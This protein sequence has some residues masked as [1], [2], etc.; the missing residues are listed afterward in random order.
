MIEFVRRAMCFTAMAACALLPLSS[1]AEFPERPVL[2]VNPYAAGGGLDTLTRAVAQRLTN[3]WG[4]QVN[5]ENRPGAGSTIGM[6]A[7]FNAKPDGYTWVVGSTPLGINPVVYPNLAY[8]VRRD[9]VPLSLIA[10]APEV[11]VVNPTLGV[12]SVAE[13]VA[14]AKGGRKMNFGSAGTGTIA[15]LAA[16][17]FIRRLALGGQHIPYKGST[18]ALVDVVGGQ[19]EGVFDTPSAVL[20]HVRSGRVRALAIA[21]PKRSAQL[22]DVPTLAEAGYPGL[23]FRTWG[24][25]LTRAGTPDAVLKRIDAGIAEVMRD[26]ALRATLTAQGWDVVGNNSREF[27]AFLD[28]ELPKLG[29]AARAAGVKPGD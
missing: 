3:L 2:I 22:P 4:Q 18:P 5:V 6:T 13:L 8:E 23:E 25:F 17:G 7:A 20:P 15:H 21:A 26:P 9:F 28:T 16:D 27:A 14:L 29:A 19:I 11:L 10:T 24:A 12:N 1:R